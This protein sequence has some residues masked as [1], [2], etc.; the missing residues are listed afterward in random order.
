MRMPNKLILTKS[1]ALAI[2]AI[3]ALGSVAPA[4]DVEGL[5]QQLSGKATAPARSAAQ[6]TDAYQK[7]IDYLLPLMS[8]EDVESRYSYQI[9]FQNM[10]SHAARP[11]AEMERETLAKV[12]VSNLEQAEM[13]ATVRHWFVLQIERIGKGESVPALVKLLSGEDRDLADYARRALE[14]NPDASATE[15]LLTAL[16]TAGES[17][18]KI[19]LINALGERQVQAALEPVAEALNDSDPKVAGAAVTALSSISGPNRGKALVGVL[20]QPTGPITLKAAQALVDIA[21]ELAKQA[22]YAAAGQI[23]DFLYRGATGKARDGDDYNPFSIRTAALNGLAICA[24][25]KLAS[26]IAEVIGDDDP[27]V[28]AVA[29]KAARLAPTKAPM[30]ILCDMLSDL[31]PYEQIQVLGLIADRGD[32]GSIKYAKEVLGS[33]DE[34]V[35]LAAID[36]LTSIGVDA[37]AEML[38]DVAINGRGATQRAADRGLVL[39]AGPRVEDMIATQAASGDAKAR[40]VALGLL[41]KR[42][43][44]GATDTLL[45]YANEGDDDIRSASFGALVDVADLVDIET[46]AGLVVETKTRTVRRSGITAL[47]AV[48]AQA[49]D[50]DAAAQVL[51]S[52]MKTS[53]ADAKIALLT[54][55]DAAGGAA[56]LDAVLDATQA[57]NEALRDAGVRTLSNWPDFAGAEELLAIASKSQTSLTHY[58]LAMRGALRLIG[59][60]DSVSL[61][62]RVTLCFKAF[63]LARRDDEKRQAIAVMGSLPSPKVAERLLSLAQEEG[64]K[65]EAGLAAVELAGRSLRTNRQAAREFAEKIRALDI[66]DEVN[67]RADGIVR[68]RRR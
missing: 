6:L 18:W 14:K 55:L 32:L 64:L 41:S 21:Q 67:R 8:A 52:Q 27:R 26:V 20:N 39:M 48:L 4:Q 58:V 61:D 63:D 43:M 38:M 35:R 47:E 46:L 22:N 68:G 53:D 3:L 65:V 9:M 15:A 57:S 17:R 50:K 51:I 11:G 36:V 60:N 33:E 13:P 37:G 59:T 45:Q 66:S 34:G 44:P 29:V 7:A 24:P 28:R 42:R 10:A 16:S 1:L 2:V 25:D 62:D 31:K 5:V 30:Q 56:A 49:Q 12:L 40:A 23:Y 19:G 54:C